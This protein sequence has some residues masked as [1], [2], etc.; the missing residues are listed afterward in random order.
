MSQKDEDEAR[1]LGRQNLGGLV[2]VPA[3][4]CSPQYA[5]LSN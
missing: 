1:M 2:Q 4:L 3:D 5:H